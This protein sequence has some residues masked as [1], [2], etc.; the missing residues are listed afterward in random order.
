MPYLIFFVLMKTTFFIKDKGGNVW[1]INSFAFCAFEIYLFN[2]S[3]NYYKYL[4]KPGHTE[5]YSND[6]D[7]LSEFM[8]FSVDFWGFDE[9]GM[10]EYFEN[11]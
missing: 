11:K 5:I 4:L 3:I 2:K 7:L 8:Q 10:I 6:Y 9:K 1:P